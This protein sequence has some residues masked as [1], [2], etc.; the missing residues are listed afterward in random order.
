[1]DK[2]V[3]IIA[4]KEN[5]LLCSLF[6]CYDSFELAKKSI[7]RSAK[8]YPN[9]KVLETNMKNEFDIVDND[10]IHIHTLK[11]IDLWLRTK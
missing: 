4:I 6:E 11:I 9:R 1:M 10:C 2:K 8:N 7:Y 5:D 3:Y